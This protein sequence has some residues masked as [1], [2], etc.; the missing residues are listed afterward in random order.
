MKNIN[1]LDLCFN[2]TWKRVL[3]MLLSIVFLNFLVSVITGFNIISN[4]S[5]KFMDIIIN[6][7]E[8][9]TQVSFNSDNWIEEDNVED[10]AP[11]SWKVEKSAEWTSNTT[12]KV[13][14]DIRTGV[15]TSENSRDI[16][17]VLD[18]SGSMDGNK[19]DRVKQDA[20]G[21]VDYVLNEEGKNNRVAVVTFSTKSQILTN[22]NNNYFMDINDITK[23]EDLLSSLEAKGGTNYAAA[24]RN[25]SKVVEGYTKESKRDLIVM[26]LTDGYP[27]EEHPSERNEYSKLKSEH[28][29]IEI[30]GVQYEMN[31]SEVIKQIKDISD[32]QYLAFQ[33]NLRNVLMEIML[34]PEVYENFELTDY[35]NDRNFEI[36]SEESVE[37]SLGQYEVDLDSQSIKWDMS[38]ELISG[39]TA[40]MSINL[41]LKEPYNTE[42]GRYPTNKGEDRKS[43][44]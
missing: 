10:L 29:Y 34:K 35:I 36:E 13:T 26:F 37:V 4:I 23:I 33:S 12:A 41:K 20:S 27:A 5:K 17:L 2:K 3:L 39:S 42:K 38:N 25:V 28:S 7:P 32:K 31:N 21:L 15:K 43:V 9:I 18:T 24:L 1:I 44:V 19:L 40:Q 14:F 16:I 22:E 8:H 30:N 11:G 6:D